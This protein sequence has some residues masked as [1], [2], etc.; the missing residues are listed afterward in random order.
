LDETNHAIYFDQ[1]GNG[2]TVRK[3]LL[4]LVLGR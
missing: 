4:A 2:V 3:A 1:A